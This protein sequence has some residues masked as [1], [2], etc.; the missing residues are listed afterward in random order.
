MSKSFKWL[1]LGLGLGAVAGLLFGLF[2]A[3]GL[4]SGLVTRPELPVFGHV[5]DFTLTNQQSQPV[6]LANLKG[7]IWLADVIFTR[8]P[9]PCVRM[10]KLMSEVQR[11]LAPADP[12]RLV[13]LTADPAYDTASVLR[14]YAERYGADGQRWHFLTGPKA[15][16]YRLAMK[17][18]LLSVEEGFPE[19]TNALENLFIHS[20]KFILVDQQG[21]LR[22]IYDGEDPASKTQVLADIRALL[23]PAALPPRVP[24][25]CP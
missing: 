21:G 7:S 6:T 11:A 9:G 1:A 15:E 17:D 25:C 2:L 5:G 4:R 13:S 20:T 12:V 23:R 14:T 3:A 22:G 10:T 16:V 19:N 18:L 24:V 8:C